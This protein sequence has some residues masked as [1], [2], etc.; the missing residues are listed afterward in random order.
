MPVDSSPLFSPTNHR[1]ARISVA[2]GLFVLLLAA[3]PLG[4]AHLTNEGG[5]ATSFGFGLSP[6]PFR[7]AGTTH[8]GLSGTFV[9]SA[10][11]WVEGETHLLPPGAGAYVP[12]P[13][14]FLALTTTGTLLTWCDLESPQWWSYGNQT[15]AESKIDDTENENWTLEDGTWDDGGWGGA[16]HSA[17]QSAVGYGASGCDGTAYAEDWVFGFSVMILAACDFLMDD[18]MGGMV[19]GM[20]GIIDEGNFGV[21]GAGVPFPG[22]GA[23]GCE[24]ASQVVFVLSYSAPGEDA[25]VPQGGWIDTEDSEPGDFCEAAALGADLPGV[26]QVEGKTNARCIYKG[27]TDRS[28]RIMNDATSGQAI[29][30]LEDGVWQATIAAGESAD[31]E[32]N[33]ITVRGVEAGKSALVRFERL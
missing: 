20:D 18:G 19:C 29:Q 33:V 8:S 12:M 7:H 24:I 21:G 30:I 28:Y 13:N 5:S 16:C 15:G 32:G 17:R 27:N 4:G 14:M 31:V 1:G 22:F 10:G 6:A 3:F 25:V 2:A 23:Y 26:V 9:G 11:T